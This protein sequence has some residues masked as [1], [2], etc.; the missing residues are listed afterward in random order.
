MGIRGT[1]GMAASMMAL[2]VVAGCGSSPSGQNADQCNQFATSYD[3]LAAVISSGPVDGAEAWD[4]AKRA[5]L[6]TIRGLTD[7][8]TDPVA[9]PLNTLVDGIPEDPLVLSEP[10]SESGQAFVDNADAVAQACSDDGTAI[11]LVD[12]PLLNFSN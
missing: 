10:E 7:S 1:A 8:A 3:A 11:S 2:A 6:D 12:F 9:G 4:A 5:E